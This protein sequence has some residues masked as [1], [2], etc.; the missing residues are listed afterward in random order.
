MPFLQVSKVIDQDAGCKQFGM[1]PYTV[2][3][4]SGQVT[5]HHKMHSAPDLTWVNFHW[6][7]ARAKMIKA[8]M[9]PTEDMP[10]QIITPTITENRRMI[11]MLRMTSM[12][13]LPGG[14]FSFVNIRRHSGHGTEHCLPV[15]TSSKS[16]WK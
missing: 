7:Q 15:S 1:S 5:R 10:T 3:S 12:L 4:K 8:L 13:S 6:E 16:K 14:D 11:E 9:G 2:T